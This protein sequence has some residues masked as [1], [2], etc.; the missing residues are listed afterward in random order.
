MA[1]HQQPATPV[2]M[3]AVH[4]SN[5]QKRQRS[6]GKSRLPPPY[7]K[8]PKVKL[9]DICFTRTMHAWIG[10]PT[11]SSDSQLCCARLACS[12]HLR[13]TPPS[14]SPAHIQTRR[15]RAWPGAACSW[16][17]FI[18]IIITSTIII[19]GTIII[20]NT[21]TMTI[22]IT[23]IIAIFPRVACAPQPEAAND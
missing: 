11:S 9:Q 23:I 8:Y 18:A 6:K 14:R 22:T 13:T 15:G 20:T 16:A 1:K 2:L 5:K 10:K 7:R 12:I 21:I 19:T 4:E 17:F 3:L